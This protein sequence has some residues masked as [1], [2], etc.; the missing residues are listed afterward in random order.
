MLYAILPEAD[1]RAA[2]VAA[3]VRDAGYTRAAQDY[4]TCVISGVTPATITR[5]T[6][7][8]YLRGIHA[9]QAA[10]Y[11]E[12]GGYV[13]LALELYCV[14]VQDWLERLLAGQTGN[15][16]GADPARERSDDLLR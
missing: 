1:A 14:V 6:A 11:D 2:H 9:L 5:R 4:A 13:P 8:S 12:F 15:A 10:L 16:S 3:T 7:Q